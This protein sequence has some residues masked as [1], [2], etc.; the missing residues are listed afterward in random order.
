MRCFR[1]DYIISWDV[2]DKDYPC[3]SVSRLREENGKLVCDVLGQS[4]A[5]SGVVSIRQ[6]LAEFNPPKMGGEEA[7]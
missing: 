3:I 7:P 1:D 2:S 5:A 4:Y 6:L